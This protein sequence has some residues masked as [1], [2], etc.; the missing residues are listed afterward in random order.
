M[1][2]AYEQLV[3]SGDLTKRQVDVYQ[4]L[5]THRR[6]YPDGMSAREINEWMG[7]ELTK[8]SGV[9]SRLR[10]LAEIGLVRKEGKKR[11]PRSKRMVNVWV[12]ARGT[13]SPS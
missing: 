11:C 10:E 2:K 12:L 1:N 8:H 4:V 5:F 6:A 13:D 3:A 7:H 9:H